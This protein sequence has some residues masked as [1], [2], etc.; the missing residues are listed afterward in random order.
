MREMGSVEVADEVWE[1]FSI[2]SLPLFW[3]LI[4]YFCLNVMNL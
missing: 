3:V 2:F 1:D 4:I